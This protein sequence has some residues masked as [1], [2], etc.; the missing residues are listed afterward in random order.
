[1]DNRRLIFPLDAKLGIFRMEIIFGW[2]VND[3]AVEDGIQCALVVADATLWSSTAGG[4]ESL[5]RLWR[6]VAR[7]PA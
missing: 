5:E 4:S 1:M 7:G 2:E 6:N 3:I